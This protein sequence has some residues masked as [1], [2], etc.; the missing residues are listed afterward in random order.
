MMVG[1]NL[2]T[3]QINEIVKK[4]IDEA[5]GNRDGLLDFEEFCRVRLHMYN[6]S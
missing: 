5:D 2:D 4:T 3:T 1:D 6:L